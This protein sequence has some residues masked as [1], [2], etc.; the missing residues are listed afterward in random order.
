MAGIPSHG[1]PHDCRRSAPC[2]APRPRGSHT[3]E[4]GDALNR[5]LRQPLEKG[6]ATIPRTHHRYYFRQSTGRS[7]VVFAVRRTS[8][9]TGSLKLR[10]RPALVGANDR[11]GEPD[12]TR[13]RRGSVPRWGISRMPGAFFQAVCLAAAKAGQIGTMRSAMSNVERRW[14]TMTRET[15]RRRIASL[16]V[17]SF[18]SSRWLVASSSSRMRGPR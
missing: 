6:H 7:P 18:S 2:C 12:K 11:T 1:P 5:S 17:R 9:G 14:A 10:Y 3:G 4:S 13:H 8:G 16:I 15:E